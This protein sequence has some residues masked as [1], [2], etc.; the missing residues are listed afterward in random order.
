MQAGRLADLDRQL[1]LEREMLQIGA[2][3]FA[4]RMNKRREQGMES[5]STHG[6]VLAAMGVDRIIRD[7]RRHRHAM[8]DG[9]A[10]RGYAHMGPLLQLAPHKV[11]AV[12]MRVIIDQL[13]QSPKFQAL[14]Y[15]LAERL[16]LETMLARASEYELKSH[17]RV[18][19]RFKQKRADAMRMR[20]TEVWTPQEKLSVGVFL[21]HLVEQHTGLIEIYAERGAMRAVKRVRGTQAALDWVRGAE[22]QQRL[23]CPFALPTIIPPR[24][25]SDPMTGG[26]WTEGLPGNTLFKENNEPIAASSSEFDAYLVAANHQQGVGWRINGWMLDQVNHAW[27]RN[28]TIGGLLPRSGHAIPPYPKHLPDDHDDVAAWRMTARRLHDRN[29]RD[30][31]KRFATA[32]QLW[33]AR[34]L[35]NEPVLYFP[36]QCD[37]RGRFYYRP[38]FLN[39]QANDV[40]RSLLQFAAGTPINTEAEADWLRIHGANTYGHNKLTWKG[41]IDWV[42]QNQLQIEATGREPWCNQEFWAG[43]KDPWQFLAFCRTYQQFS[44]HG[45]GWVCHHPVVLDCTCSGIQHYSALLR[46]E[47][48]AALVNLT[49]SETPRDIYAVVLERVL[50]LV[51]ADAAGGN[52]HAAR[53][54]QLSPDRTLAK[55]VVMT[56][57]YSATREAVV[58]FCCGWAQDRAQDVLGRD[59][60]CFKKGAMSSHHYMATIL[61]RETSA[62]IAPAKAAM[63]WFR[64]VGKTAGKLGLALRWTSPSGVPV[65][66]EYWDYSGVRVRLYH[67]S[68]VPMDLLTNHQPTEL[69]VKRMGNGL[70]PNVI[71]SLDASHMAAVTIEAFASGVRNLGGIHDCFA[72]TPAEMATLRTTIRST[73]AGMYARD[74]FTPIAD[75]LTD[76]FPPDVQAKLP[77]R[78]SLGGF[79]PQLVNNAD[80]F[81]T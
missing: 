26:Y 21:V 46:S 5:L 12:A 22:E 72:T 79:D 64:K 30:A 55:P 2:D 81:V 71:H 35:V 14:A 69:N 58:N 25:W 63:S 10:G 15:A 50:A 27:D 75:E 67:L 70:S 73:F 74:W 56:I 68:S 49:P 76:Q 4:S 54:L 61:Y 20:N 39:P 6:D 62:L 43:A 36:V 53:W 34:R 66:Q 7:L 45:Y 78:P 13:T 37:F 17:Q 65:I 1:A 41:R 16:W 3:S 38:P 40:G 8:R 44:H 48:M 52:E 32:K 33:V 9:R 51:R 57:P 11:A 18:R 19:R 24:D 47:E 31:A 77:P 59:S 80:Y 42:H 60:W 29:D 23:L 28:L